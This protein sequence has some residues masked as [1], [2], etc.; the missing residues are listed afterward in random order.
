MQYKINKYIFSQSENFNSYKIRLINLRRLIEG[1]KCLTTI[2]K[3]SPEQLST[4]PVNQIETEA[5]PSKVI[6]FFNDI[7][8]QVLKEFD[9]YNKI[10]R[11]N[12]KRKI[13]DDSHD[14]SC[15]RDSFPIMTNKTHTMF[16]SYQIVGH[17]EDRAAISLFEFDEQKCEINTNNFIIVSQN[18]NK[19]CNVSSAFSSFTSSATTTLNGGGGVVGRVARDQGG[20][21]LE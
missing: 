14:F 6:S 13:S 11:Y 20:C 19:Y 2:K 17:K 10:I 5:V 21:G 16:V 1:V 9:D 4:S 3:L 15:S 18:I 7:Q 12:F 8:I